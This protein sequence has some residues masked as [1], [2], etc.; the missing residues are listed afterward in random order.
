MRR[1]K[2][3]LLALLWMVVLVVTFAL[4]EGSPYGGD[5]FHIYFRGARDFLP[6]T[7]P[8]PTVIGDTQVPYRYPPLLAQLLIPLAHAVDERTA[9]QL[10]FA[11]DVV[12]LLAAVVAFAREVAPERRFTLWLMVLA[13]VPVFEAMRIGQ[14]TVFLLVLISFAWLA[15]KHDRP[16][17]AGVLLAFAA[18]IKLYPALILFYF[19]WKRNWRVVGAALVS[20]VLM[21]L[22]QLAIS[23]TGIFVEFYNSLVIAAG[24]AEADLMWRNSSIYGFAARLFGDYERSIPL[25]V[26]P[27]L[28][29]LARYGLMALVIGVLFALTFRSRP[30]EGER[31]DL[32]YALAVV[33]MLLI[34]PW[35]YADS[36]SPALM[37]IF[38]LWKQ[39]T[40]RQSQLVL[41]G[42]LV[43]LFANYLLMWQ[44]GESFPALVLSLGFY[45]LAILWGVIVVRLLRYPRAGATPVQREAEA[46]RA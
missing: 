42:V 32:E 6:E 7:L 19:L 41:I 34:S 13:F 21:G 25:L 15:V 27:A 29:T 43:L 35:M 30:R 36:V 26:S 31:F 46:A 16:L 17:I 39:R 11:A 28:F 3:L 44:P 14:V 24:N 37:A 10:W 45:A 12:A 22:F 33:T 40:S 18:W 38:I 23:G 2:W 4:M 8:Y 9:T 20:G 5:D 1:L